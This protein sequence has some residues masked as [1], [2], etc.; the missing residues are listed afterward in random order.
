MNSVEIATPLRLAIRG[1]SAH[2][3]LNYPFQ[4]FMVDA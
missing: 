1:Y 2:A 4:P 3:C